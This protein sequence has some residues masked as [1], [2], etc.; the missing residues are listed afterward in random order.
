MSLKKKKKKKK[1][2][3]VIVLCLFSVLYQTICFFFPEESRQNSIYILTTAKV[4]S[5]HTFHHV[6]CNVEL[7]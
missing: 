1:P 6:E 4:P 7:C 2:C 5:E 3:E